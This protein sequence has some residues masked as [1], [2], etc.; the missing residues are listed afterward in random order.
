MS[1]QYDGQLGANRAGHPPRKDSEKPFWVLLD[2]AQR[3]SLQR[4]AHPINR[5]T[6]RPREKHP[7]NYSTRGCTLPSWLP[8]GHILHFC[9]L[10][11]VRSPKPKP[12]VNQ[13]IGTVVPSFLVHL[14]RPL[15]V[16]PRFRGISARPL[17]AF[18][19][20]PEGPRPRLGCSVVPI[21]CPLFLMAAPLKQVSPPQ[22]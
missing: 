2:R 22:K 8:S 4:F 9:F 17:A 18:F 11:L 5:Q 13:A 20:C 16:D 10:R 1:S 21:I 6:R 14:I 15:S 3:P 7:T 19:P 12:N